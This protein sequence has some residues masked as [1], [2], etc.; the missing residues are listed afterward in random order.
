MRCVSIAAHLLLNIDIGDSFGA[1][2]EAVPHNRLTGALEEPIG[3]TV[4]KYCDPDRHGCD[5]C[6]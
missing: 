1:P 3:N 5:V 2:P 6:E 4:T